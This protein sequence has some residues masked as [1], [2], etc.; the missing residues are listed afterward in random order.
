M[1]AFHAHGLPKGQP[2]A[3]AFAFKGKARVFD[4]GTAEGW[5]SQIAE[6]AR[7]VLPAAPLTGPI[8]MNVDFF[9]PRPKAH[10]LKAGL[11]ATAPLWHR[12]KPDADNAAKAVMDALTTLR[13]WEDDAQ[14]VELVVR[15]F[16]AKEIQ[17][18]GALVT[19]EALEGVA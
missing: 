13:A 5:K 17:N 18:A 10:Y 4:P 7:P 16:Y 14:V 9:F 8:R 6:A 2:R 1:I 3:R 12:S 11:R 19:I 15:K